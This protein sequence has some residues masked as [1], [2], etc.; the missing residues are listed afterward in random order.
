MPNGAAA[1]GAEDVRM[2]LA[3]ALTFHASFDHGPDADFALGDP[4]LHSV[5]TA[6][7]PTPGLGD[8]PVTIAANRG[9]FGSALELTLENTHVVLYRA[10]HNVA[11]SP[12]AFRGTVSLWLSVDPAEIP[13]QY[14]DPLQ[15]TDKKYSD[16]CIWVDF[17]KN[18]TPSDFRLGVFG[19]AGV[20][21][22][23]GKEGGGERFFWRLV[24]VAE[25][26]FAKGR[27]T[28]IVITWDGLNDTQAGRARLYFDGQFQG[29]TGRIAE[30][31]SWDVANAYIRLGT[32]R[33]VGL[34][35][36]LA[37]FNRALT[38]A[39]VRALNALTGGVAE[40]REA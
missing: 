26:P 17:T 2:A 5:S 12:E 29:A 18:D 28:H 39:E 23:D 21:D 20:W 25:P 7:P 30:P 6:G 11:Y 36:D 22:P 15:V 19:D 37:F 35:D 9:K 14:C 16:A 32:G 31:F 40:L 13:G 8:P 10:E 34:F 3:K 33:Y 4:T 24:K 1:A 27:W 38:P